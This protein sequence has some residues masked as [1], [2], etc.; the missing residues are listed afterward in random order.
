MSDLGVAMAQALGLDLA[1]SRLEAP[2]S[3]SGVPVATLYE[4]VIRLDGITWQ[5]TDHDGVDWI[6]ESLE[7]WADMPESNAPAMGRTF[8]HGAWSG[9]GWFGPRPLV[10]HGAIVAPDRRRLAAALDELR[11]AYAEALEHSAVLAVEELDGEKRLGV[12]AGNDRLAVSYVAPVAARVSISLFAPWPVK[13]S[14]EL[15]ASTVGY[16]RGL[17]RHYNRPSV[18]GEFR[19]YGPAG[20]LGNLFLDLTGNAPIRPRFLIE[21]PCERPAIIAADQNRR[22]IFDITL[23]PGD[24]LGVD[25]DTHS[26][27]LNDLANRRFVLTADSAWFDLHPGMNVLQY[28]PADNGGRITVYY[29]NGWW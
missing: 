22:L 5:S 21:G 18:D 20:A 27:L 19:R 13:R 9:P 15:T 29:A 14:P 11:A 28:R 2:S 10:L 12:R 17:G 24:L 7:G 25:V 4:P 1:G 16:E 26:V 6:C 3:R 23:A 8:D